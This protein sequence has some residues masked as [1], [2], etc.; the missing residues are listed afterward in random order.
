VVTRL[1]PKENEMSDGEQS[2]TFQVSIG[3]TVSAYGIVEVAAATP[4]EAVDKAGAHMLV[5]RATP[6]TLLV[7]TNDETRGRFGVSVGPERVLPR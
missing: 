3:A 7:L 2:R 6:L 4:E 1:Q 5:T